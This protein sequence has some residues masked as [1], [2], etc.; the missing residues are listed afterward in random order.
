MRAS[1]YVV[2]PEAVHQKTSPE[3]A[4]KMKA[5]KLIFAL[6]AL[7]FAVVSMAQLKHK[8]FV[9]KPMVQER[10]AGL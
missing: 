2:F 6:A 10:R 9:L 7:S 8:P 1:G 4:S 5:L 3:R